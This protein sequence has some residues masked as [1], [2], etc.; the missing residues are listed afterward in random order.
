MPTEISGSTGVNKVQDSSITSAKIADGA[1]TNTD[2]NSSAAIAGSKLVMPSGSVLQVKSASLG[3]TGLETTSSTFADMCTVT[4]TPTSSSNKVLILASN[5][6][7]YA[8]SNAPQGEVSVYSDL[9]SAYIG[10]CS[11]YQGQQNTGYVGGGTISI[12]QAL[13]SW[14][15][16]SITYR[17]KGRS[18]NNVYIQLAAYGLATLTVMEIAG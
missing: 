9:S 14:S 11:T 2:I 3:G 12:E 15:S 4:I 10:N 7:T 17:L 5:A 8:I 16:G 6:Q 13:S 18:R 1:I